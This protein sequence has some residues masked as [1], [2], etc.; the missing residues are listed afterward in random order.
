MENPARKGLLWSDMDYQKGVHKR[1]AYEW[2]LVRLITPREYFA[3]ILIETALDHI[4]S[5]PELE[6]TKVLLY[7]QSIGGAVALDLASRNKQTV[8]SI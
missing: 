6:K 2:M 4:T 5:H 3:D 8:R 1:K 7:G